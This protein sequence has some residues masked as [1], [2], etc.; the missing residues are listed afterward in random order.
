MK[1]VVS[2]MV[3]GGLC[4][5]RAAGF[6]APARARGERDF[7]RASVVLPGEL[8]PRTQNLQKIYR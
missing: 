6:A 5:L 2:A 3:D 4:V 8:S 7:L 1:S